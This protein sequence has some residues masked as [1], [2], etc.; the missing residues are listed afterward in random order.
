MVHRWKKRGVW[1]GVA[2]FLAL[3][4]PLLAHNLQILRVELQEQQAPDYT[5][6][7]SLPPT[8]EFLSGE[9]T[10]PPRCQ[11]RRS[12][13]TLKR[14][15]IL[16]REFQFS[17]PSEPLNAK[18]SIGLPWPGEG[19]FVLNTGKDGSTATK[20]FPSVARE[21][22]KYIEIE[23]RQFKGD[24]LAIADYFFLGVQ[25]ILEG[26]DHLAFVLGLCLIAKGWNLVKL[27]TG[28]T[29]GHSLSL[30]L[31]TFNIIQLP[32]PPV[33]ACI[34][35]SIAFMARQAFVGSHSRPQ[36][37]ALVVAFG[38]L[39]GLGF[40]GILREYNLHQN[41][42]LLGLVSFNLGVEGGQLIF[43]AGVIGLL[44]LGS[45][46][47]TPENLRRVVAYLIGILGMF[48]TIQR[49][50]SFSGSY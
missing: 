6:T 42:L 36:E 29:L 8:S 46:F 32:S 4:T 41:D 20:F 34:A 13:V 17:C 25:H 7:V 49:L 40:A 10:L 12:P 39:H 31:A 26:W 21:G 33:E 44:A 24:T 14:R 38:L 16:V 48:W 15:G 5:L 9:P 1:M 30:A 18:D 22:K 27:V 47:F 11:L 50:V 2:I 37:V 28:F 43:V 3:A 45:K 19:A 23:M 35:L